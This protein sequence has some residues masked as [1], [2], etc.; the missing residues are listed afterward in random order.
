M[1]IHR[2]TAEAALVELRTV[3]E[4]LGEAEAQRRLSE[5]G[6]NRIAVARRRNPA[7]LLAQEFTQ[8]FPIVMWIAAALAFLLEREAPGE[9]MAHLGAALIVVIVVS[10][11]FSYWQEFRAAKTLAALMRLL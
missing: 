2:L 3:P 6:P 5:Y 7:L 4:G 11:L 1:S 10:G 9:G 8:L